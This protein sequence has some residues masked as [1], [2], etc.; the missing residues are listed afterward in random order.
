LKNTNVFDLV[1]MMSKTY[2]QQ[3]KCKWYGLSN[4]RSYRET[5][6]KI[7]EKFSFKTNYTISNGARKNW[8]VLMKGRFNSDNPNTIKINWYKRHVKI[9]KLI[10]HIKLCHIILMVKYNWMVN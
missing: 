8:Q 10:G 5:I 4:K 1:K 7:K 2:V 3:F 9:R 6:T